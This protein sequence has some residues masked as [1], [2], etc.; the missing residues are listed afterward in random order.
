[1]DGGKLIIYS[2]N[3]NS[4]KRF[5]DDLKGFAKKLGLVE[6]SPILFRK[7]RATYRRSISKFKTTPIHVWVKPCASPSRPS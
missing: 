6:Q 1:V 4:K 5:S 7:I 2:E 3:I